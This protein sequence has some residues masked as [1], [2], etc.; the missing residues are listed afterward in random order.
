[1]NTVANNKNG[2]FPQNIRQL[3]WRTG[4]PPETLRD[5]AERGLLPQVPSQEPSE[6]AFD[7]LALLRGLEEMNDAD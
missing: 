5:F 1:M 2:N 6:P 4:F 7:G 3:S